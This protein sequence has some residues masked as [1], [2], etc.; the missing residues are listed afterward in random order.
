MSSW[1]ED[2]YCAGTP[3]DVFYAFVPG[4]RKGNRSQTR[5]ELEREVIA[6]HCSH[7]K[8]QTQCL[9]Q[10]VTGFCRPGKVSLDRRLIPVAGGKTSTEVRDIIIARREEMGF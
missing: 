8:V 4:G 9:E 2:R 1:T 10:V 3:P 5:D 6:T 7:C